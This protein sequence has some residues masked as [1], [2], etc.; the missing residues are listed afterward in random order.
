[1]T[2][3]DVTK[4]MAEECL[5]KLLQCQPKVDNELK[6]LEAERKRALRAS[7]IPASVIEFS[8]LPEE[9]TWGTAME[10]RLIGAAAARSAPW[11]VDVSDEGDRL[12]VM[13]GAAVLVSDDTLD[14]VAKHGQ[15]VLLAPEDILP[16]DGDLVALNDA[17]G[18]RYLRRIWSDGENWVLQSVNPVSPV[19]GVLVE[20]RAAAAR[21]VI[22]VVYEPVLPISPSSDKTTEWLPST[23]L[24]LGE[25]ARCHAIEVEGASLDPI[26]RPGQKV[27]VDEKCDALDEVSAGALAV[28][29][30]SAEAVGNVVK[31][32]FPR[33]DGWILVSPNP[34]DA[35]PPDILATT[36]I[37]SIRCVRGVLFETAEA[38]S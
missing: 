5:A 32:V 16:N 6:R 36:E 19:P 21:R 34:V 26:A 35:I 14:P 2:E 15:W 30:S 3:A 10:L 28:V 23:H 38:T 4:P 13:P 9:A 33:S 18:N 17:E 31:R 7:I 27:L 12:T 37:S 1:M 25:F 29:E 8:Q 22:G 11:V 24:D 20:K